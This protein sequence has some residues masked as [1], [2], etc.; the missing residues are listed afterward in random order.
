MANF[1]KVMIDKTIAQHE[2]CNFENDPNDEPTK[3]GIIQDDIIESMGDGFLPNIE[4]I[5]EYIKNLTLDQ[6]AS[7]HKHLYFD[8]LLLAKLVYQTV[9]DK[10]FDMALPIGRGKATLCAQR[11][12][13]SVSA[14]QKKI[15][16]DGIMGANTLA[17]INL[18]FDKNFLAAFRSE[19]A[20][21]C[22]MV[23]KNKPVKEKF[24]QGWL[25]RSYAL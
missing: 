9:A 15:E 17:A 7:I 14:G 6:A 23:V 12:C 11:A 21:Y 10:I 1:S 24:L 19:C 18:C 2:G 13:R 4:N 16:E 5:I 3:F 22:R 20:G 25:E 8:K